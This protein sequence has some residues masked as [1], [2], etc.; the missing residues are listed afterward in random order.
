M[1]LLDAPKF[2]EARDHRNQIM[3]VGAAGLAG[4]SIDRGLAYFRPC[5]STG[6]GTGGRICAAG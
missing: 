2:D 3:L 1:T 5:P 6:P 4:G